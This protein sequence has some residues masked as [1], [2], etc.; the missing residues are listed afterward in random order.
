MNL[1]F[2]GLLCHLFFITLEATFTRARRRIGDAAKSGSYLGRKGHVGAKRDLGAIDGGAGGAQGAALRNRE[3]AEGAGRRLATGPADC[4]GILRDLLGVG[5]GDRVVGD[6]GY[7]G[8]YR[9][10]AG[11]RE[12]PPSYEAYIALGG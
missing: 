11:E 5:L 4:G 1:P 9:A 12:A 2:A 7:H 10:L 3:G 8:V 6:A